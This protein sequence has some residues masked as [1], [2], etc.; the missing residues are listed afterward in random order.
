M[1]PMC[2]LAALVAMG[3]IASVA[4]QA[5]AASP[6]VASATITTVSTGAT[7]SYSLKLTDSA[8]SP[9]P[10][11]TFWFAWIPG[12]DF[13]DTSPLS[14][15]DPTGWT[16]NITHGGPGDGYAIQ[17]LASTPAADVTIGSSLSGFGF[18]STDSPA[19]ISGDSAFFPTTPVLTSFAY[20]AAPFSDSGDKFLVTVVPEPVSLA[21]LSPM[22]LLLLR[23]SRR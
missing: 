8:A 1:R 10:I 4:R 19:S 18:T 15:T 13:L 7:N 9:S 11:G 23:R 22:A 17:F 2:F 14:V 12:E 16:D 3:S 20:D 6:P 5:A 21:L